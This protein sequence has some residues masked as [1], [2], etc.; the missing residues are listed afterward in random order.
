MDEAIQTFMRKNVIE[1]QTTEA[2]DMILYMVC[3][4]T[5]GQDQATIQAGCAALGQMIHVEQKAVTE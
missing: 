3:S 1:E 2:I 4:L 5:A